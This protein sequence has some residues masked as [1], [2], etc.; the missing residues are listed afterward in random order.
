MAKST[1]LAGNALAVLILKLM[2]PFAVRYNEISL[3]KLKE[4][5][6]YTST[7][8]VPRV[9]KV[10]VNCGI[11]DILTNDKAVEE[12]AKLL[13]AITGQKPVETKAH[14]A[15]S[16]FKIR[17]DMVVGLKVTL[18]GARMQD[19]IIKLSDLALP[20]TR[21]FRGLKPS[22]ITADGNLNIG[23]KDSLIFPETSQ[24]GL[25][26]ILQV[27]LVSTAKTTEEARLL[28]ESLNFYFGNEE[29]LRD[30][31]KPGKHQHKRK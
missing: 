15:I 31:K 5:K 18:R 14:K 20:R 11:G 1:A 21:D 19:F 7:F 28:F 16:G 4:V 10:S 13:T 3:P 2:H 30:K 27:T 23:I 12:V 6:H 26:H 24:E 9:T 25:G 17:Q 29:E 8:L 22:S